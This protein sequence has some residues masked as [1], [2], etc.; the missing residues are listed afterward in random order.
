MG[1]YMWQWGLVEK[2][3]FGILSIQILHNFVLRFLP[4]SLPRRYALWISIRKWEWYHLQLP[5]FWLAP[6]MDRF[7]CG[8]WLVICQSKDQCV[9]RLILKESI[10]LNSWKAALI[11]WV[12][13]MIRP[14]H[15]GTHDELQECLLK[16]VMKDRFI[17]QVCIP[18]NPCIWQQILGD[19]EWFGI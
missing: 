18:T 19:L 5:I 15:Y 9:F 13:P 16:K 12:P 14:G 3:G 11:S 1:L 2:E 4:S 6:Q 17:H 8:V 7:C 10:T